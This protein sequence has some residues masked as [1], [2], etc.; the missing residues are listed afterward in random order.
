METQN[1]EYF[2]QVQIKDSITLAKES[3]SQNCFQKYIDKGSI[4]E[5][6]IN[7]CIISVGIGLLALPQKVQYV[8]LVFTPILIIFFALIN[9]WTFTVLGDASRKLKVN[10]YEDIVSALFS[11]R[12]T[13]F[14]HFCDVFWPFWCDY[15]FP[16]NSL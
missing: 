9:Y 5:C 10:K 13:F 14:F 1:S 11:Q 8:T 16:S 12:F 4:N 7:L 3:A 15:T 2:Q 6:V